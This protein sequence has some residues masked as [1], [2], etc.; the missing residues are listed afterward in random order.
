MV[1]CDYVTGRTDMCWANLCEGGTGD[2]GVSLG[3]L[4]HLKINRYK[5][6]DKQL[7]SKSLFW[8]GFFLRVEQMF[9]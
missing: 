4:S 5:K 8:L 7:V 1:V 6:L 2:K 3:M 9:L